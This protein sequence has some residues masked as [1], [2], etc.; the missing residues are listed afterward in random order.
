MYIG[1]EVLEIK[2]EFLNL[3]CVH[4]TMDS[5]DATNPPNSAPSLSLLRQDLMM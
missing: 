2:Q 3:A 1:K 4:Q 5:L